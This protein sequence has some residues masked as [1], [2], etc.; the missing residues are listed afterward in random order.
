[1]KLAD[2]LSE[3]G[4]SAAEFARRIQVGSRMSV[5]RYANGERIPRPDVMARI[6]AQTDGEVQPN[7]FFAPH[8][9]LGGLSAG[10]HAA[11]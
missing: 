3:R 8:P 11:E 5:L 4:I 6:V 9:S 7:D 1:M 10:A 2:Y